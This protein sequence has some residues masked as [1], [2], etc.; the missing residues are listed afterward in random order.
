METHDVTLAR[1]VIGMTFDCSDPGAQATFWARALGYIESPP[2]AGWATWEAFLTDHEVPEEEWNDG[3]GICDPADPAI[4]ISFLKVAENKSAKN[5]LHLD[6]KVSGG[7]D[8][9]AAERTQLIEAKV[10]DLVTAGAT[11]H[12]RH[13]LKGHLDHVVLLDPE[14]NELCVV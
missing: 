7:R 12:E 8:R 1:P 4:T 14:G 11:L 3:A 10:A 13:E 5:R 9:P 6:L 2:P